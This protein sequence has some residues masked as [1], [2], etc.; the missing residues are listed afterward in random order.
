MLIEILLEFFIGIVDVKLFK[1]VHLQE[2]DLR[3]EK[4]VLL[5]QNTKND[6]EKSITIIFL[7]TCY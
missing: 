6:V 2:K 1:P 5:L 3:G 4:S 7:D